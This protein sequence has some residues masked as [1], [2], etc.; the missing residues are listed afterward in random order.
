VRRPY[1]LGSCAAAATG[2]SSSNRTAH[3]VFIAAGS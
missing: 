1:G 2:R 3:R